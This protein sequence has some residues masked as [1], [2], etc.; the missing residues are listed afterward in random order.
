MALNFSI[1]Q[2]EMGYW[3]WLAV[4][5][6]VADFFAGAQGSHR[7]CDLAQ[8]L[9]PSLP[10]GTRCCDDPTPGACDQ[11]GFLSD[12]LKH[13][14]HFNRTE[15]HLSS[16]STI[17]NEITSGNPVALLLVYRAGIP[18]TVAVSDAYE[19]NN[20]QILVVDDPDSLYGPGITILHGATH[21]PTASWNM[22][23]FTQ[24]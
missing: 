12:A 16:F 19:Y 20:Q 13:V 17:E 22:T 21:V 11:T 23:Y 2:Q 5:A 7:Q 24:P 4:A 14:S 8:M 10:S 3:C 1:Q 18:H 9:V 15:K 6:S